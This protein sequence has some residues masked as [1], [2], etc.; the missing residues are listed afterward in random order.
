M[1]SCERNAQEADA[2]KSKA[3][4]H[5]RTAS[6]VNLPFSVDSKARREITE[7]VIR[8]CPS[9]TSGVC[10]RCGILRAFA[11]CAKLRS[12]ER[13]GE[14]QRI[15]RAASVP[16][17]STLCCKLILP[18]LGSIDPNPRRMAGMRCLPV[19]K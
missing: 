12:R 15:G 8:D 6:C 4:P 19:G 11:V 14:S 18:A 16:V 13:S 9:R 3:R 1:R 10:R 5:P 7:P 2:A 17:P